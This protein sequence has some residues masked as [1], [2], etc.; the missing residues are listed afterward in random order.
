ME[1]LKKYEEINLKDFCYIYPNGGCA[2]IL[3]RILKDKY[4]GV[5]FIG[6]DDREE[7]SSFKNNV[8]AIKE[9]QKYVLLMGGDV[10]EECKERCK[11]AKVNY[12]DGREYV[13]FVLAQEIL[14]LSA[15][16]GAEFRLLEDGKILHILEN[17]WIRHYY[18]FY[19]LFAY[20]CPKNALE[21]LRECVV[22]Y[23]KATQREIEKCGY[24]FRLEN[25]I[26]FDF[27]PHILE[28]YS[29]LLQD[30]KVGWYFGSMEYY[31]KNK[32]QIPKG[33]ILIAPWVIADYFINYKVVLKLSGGLPLLN[34][35][36]RK[37]VGLG[38]SLAEAFALAPKSI[39]QKNINQYAFYYFFPF[40]YYCSMDRESS[41]A[42]LSIFN[43][44]G[45]EVGLCECGSPRLDYKNLE[46]ISYKTLVEQYLF[47]PRLMK[48]EELIEAIRFLLN[49]GKKVM[50]RPHPALK[51]YIEYMGSD[52]PYKALEEFRGHS[53][54]S[55]DLSE[56]ISTQL[57]LQSIVISDNSSVTYSTPFSVC[58]PIIIYANPKKEFDLRVKNFGISFVNA[59]LH[60]VALNLEEFKQQAL[61]L[62]EDLKNNGEEII[63]DLKE[64]KKEQIYHLENS[65]KY[66]AKFLED[67]LKAF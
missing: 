41:K 38:H 36:K 3:V 62:E 39:K 2:E 40:S 57:L 48:A 23:C 10:Y 56:K 47:I 7:Q 46:K 49:K 33:N 21:E 17:P 13:A 1:Y 64:Y 12:I 5:D 26:F 35:Q 45:L 4:N 27:A 63:R 55:F 6:I 9:S 52:N 59:K 66:L 20:Y 18:F 34:P 60:R 43:Q 8:E 51:N 53:N 16:G 32:A 61:K 37:L 29:N 30:I 14:K 54:F 24:S 65:A 22:D 67:L 31:N 50:F 44:V 19:D 28:I 15:G 25:G 58:K 42:F 11:S